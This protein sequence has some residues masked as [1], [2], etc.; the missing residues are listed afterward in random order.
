MD[1][2]LKSILPRSIAVTCHIGDTNGTCST[3]YPPTFGPPALSTASDK[4]CILFELNFTPVQCATLKCSDKL[5]TQK[6]TD[7]DDEV[8]KVKAIPPCLLQNPVYRE[9]VYAYNYCMHK[10][11]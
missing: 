8:Q 9:L 6:Q 7:R 3:F 5:S 11:P 1:I 10:Y 4:L 2:L